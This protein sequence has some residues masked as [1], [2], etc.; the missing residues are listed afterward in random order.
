MRYVHF[1]FLGVLVISTALPDFRKEAQKVLERYK[2]AI[3]DY[4]A[5]GISP[6]SVYEKLAISYER[7]LG[8]FETFDAEVGE[9]VYNLLVD[10]D[11]WDLDFFGEVLEEVDVLVGLGDDLALFAQKYGMLPYTGASVESIRFRHNVNRLPVELFRKYCEALHKM[12]SIVGDIHVNGSILPSFFAANHLIYIGF[13]NYGTPTN[14]ARDQLDVLLSRQVG[15][16]FWSEET[17]LLFS[18]NCPYDYVTFINLNII[19]LLNGEAN[20][21]WNSALMT[22]IARLES[23]C[24]RT[25]V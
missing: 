10:F 3:S 21:E 24:T 9:F 23:K 13:E 15:C 5:D 11:D 22:E 2:E 14:E 6:D 19:R 12:V 20:S 1:L 4:S 17:R 25:S 18:I 16:E 8:Q 7:L